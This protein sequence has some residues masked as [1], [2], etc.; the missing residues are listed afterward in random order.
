LEPGFSPFM[1]Q[2]CP[3]I[4]P[5]FASTRGLLHSGKAQRFPDTAN[6]LF[7]VGRD[8][9]VGP[10][11]FLL[12]DGVDF[13]AATFCAGGFFC[14][15]FFAMTPPMNEWPLLP[16]S[17]LSCVGLRQEQAVPLFVGRLGV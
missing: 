1:W 7:T 3:M 6:S 17:V 5:L 13:F 9:A 8:G 12:L 2:I 11:F 16:A 15:P 10:A 14:V 4:E